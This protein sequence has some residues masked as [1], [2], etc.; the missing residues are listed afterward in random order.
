M[1]GGTQ[2]KKANLR[3]RGG[4]PRIKKQTKKKKKLFLLISKYLGENI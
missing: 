4:A 3:I 2:N 1:G